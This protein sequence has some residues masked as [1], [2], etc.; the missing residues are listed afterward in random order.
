MIYDLFQI[1]LWVTVILLAI[2]GI[3]DLYLDLLYWFLRR[4]HKSKFPDFSKMHDKPEKPVAVMLGAWKESGVIGRTLSYAIGNLKY[5]NFRIFVGVYP[6]DTETIRIVK[7]IAL[8]D[9]RV[10]VCINPQNGPTTKADNLNSL[11]AAISDFEKTFG[12]FEII[13]VHDAEDFIHPYS[14]KLYNFLIGYN[15]YHGIQIPVVPIRSKLGNLFHRTYCDAF[16]EIHTKDM[17]VRQGMGTFIP[18]SGTG[19][20]FHRKAMYHLEKFY[21]KKKKNIAEGTTEYDYLDQFG[22][23]VEMSEVYF[24]NVESETKTALIN[25]KT[26]YHDDPFNSLNIK[27]GNYKTPSKTIVRRFTFA[28]ML[29][30][31]SGISY[32]IYLGSG[33]IGGTSSASIY[34][35]FIIQ[36]AFASDKNSTGFLNQQSLS[37]NSNDIKE[38]FIDVKNNA[39]YIPLKDGIFG[40]QES[41]WGS[42]E[43]ADERLNLILTY[44]SLSHLIGFVIESKKDSKFKY[45]V[46]IGEYSSIDDAR[47]DIIKIREIF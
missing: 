29:T 14:M 26:N 33:E 6:N 16:A 35:G 15:G 1:F 5:K 28:F 42:K 40:I 11:Y 10:K 30:L 45:E 2:S 47:K 31:F 36:N 23:K 4:R 9:S 25:N 44:P 38:G 19:M 21:E 24:H 27:R 41:T 13:I 20:G 39:A 7:E 12:E 8:K 34:G 3:D 37:E 46:V 32:L 22:K 18:F 17:I 43:A